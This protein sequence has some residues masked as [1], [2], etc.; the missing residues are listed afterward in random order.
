M[1]IKSVDRWQLPK[2]PREAYD[3]AKWYFTIFHPSRLV[4]YPK[5]EMSKCEAWIRAV[6]TGIGKFVKGK[7]G[8]GWRKCHTENYWCYYAVELAKDKC[9]CKLDTLMLQGCQCGGK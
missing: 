1:A 2:T 4:W 6:E 9:I 8:N 7:H 3:H 5:T